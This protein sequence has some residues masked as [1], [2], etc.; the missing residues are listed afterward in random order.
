[1]H[2]K[3]TCISNFKISNDGGGNHPKNALGRAD[4]LRYQ[5]ITSIVNCE[6]L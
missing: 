6:R 4:V 2:W 3:G 1:M 5:Y